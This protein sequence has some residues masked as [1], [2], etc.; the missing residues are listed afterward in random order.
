MNTAF[1]GLSAALALIATSSQQAKIPT[2]TNVPV[3]NLVPLDDDARRN[4][5][6]S[7]YFDGIEIDE[8]KLSE[9]GFDW[10]L[11]RYKSVDRPNGPLWLVPHDDE[12]A[13][14]DAMI[15]AIKD[16]GGIGIAVNSGPGSLR[17]QKG[18]GVCG[19][20]Q[21]VRENCDPNRNF[22]ANSPYYTSSILDQLPTGQ[23]VI[24]LHTNSPGFSGDGHGGRGTITVLDLEAFKRGELKPRKDAI[25][26]IKPEELMANFDTLGLAPYRGKDGTPSGTTLKCGR[27]IADAGIHFWYENVVKTDASMSNYLILNRPEIAYFNAESR[28]EVDLAVASARHRIMVKAYLERCVSGDKPA[29]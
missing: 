19:A 7:G 4:S 1:M 10:H 26:A 28:S 23:P 20:S 21:R 16:H 22:D 2:W 14:F 15:T 9:N 5:I 25:F 3:E 11:I 12:N 17:M 13:A 6:N 18:Q 27:D 29:P 8:L 24:A